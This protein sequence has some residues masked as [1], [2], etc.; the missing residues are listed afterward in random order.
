MK[1]LSHICC[2][3]DRD[4]CSPLLDVEVDDFGQL[5][6]MELSGVENVKDDEELEGDVG[7]V[8]DLL[9]N[10]LQDGIETGLPGV[11]DRLR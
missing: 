1:A 4:K 10:N 9:Q 6:E 3:S 8:A 7:R 11:R 2:D 5:D